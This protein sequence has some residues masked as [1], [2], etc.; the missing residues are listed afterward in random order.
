MA[1][2]VRWHLIG[3]VGSVRGLIVMIATEGIYMT[4]KLSQLLGAE[5]PT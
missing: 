1:Q 2:R 4:P 5:K 3:G